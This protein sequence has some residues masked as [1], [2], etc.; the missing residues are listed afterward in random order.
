MGR[1]NVLLDDGGIMG[2]LKTII[3][4]YQRRTFA[5]AGRFKKGVQLETDGEKSFL[6]D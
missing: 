6:V 4:L 2:Q 5:V 1:I 3:A